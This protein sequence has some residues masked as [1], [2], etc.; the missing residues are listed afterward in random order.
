M[1]LVQE[2]V[3]V[4]LPNKKYQILIG[5]G[6]HQSL[7]D[8]MHSLQGE[9]VILITDDKVAGFWLKP[10]ASQMS[11]IVSRLDE[12]VVREGEPSKSVETCNQLWQK[13]LEMGTDR[14]TIVVAL[15]GGVVGDLA[16]FLAASFARGIRFVQIPTSLLA[17]VDSSVGGKV[18]INLPQSK[19]MVGAFWQ[20]ESVIIDPLVLQ[21]L[22]EPNFRAGMAEVIKYGLIMDDEF[23]HFLKSSVDPIRGRDP[24][25][26]AKVIAWC[27]RCKAQVVEEDEK[28]TSGRRVILNY[29][30]T[31][32]HA[33]ENVFGYGTFLHGEA[34]AIGM[35]CAARLA[36]ELGMVDSDF[37]KS[38]T[39]L[40]LEFG[41]PVECPENRHDELLDAMKRDKKVAA[42]KLSLI[43]PTRIG[44]VVS[45]AAPSDEK[46]RNSLV[47]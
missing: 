29:G 4:T 45:M 8:H 19:N 24:Q 18:G 7:P 13:M 3:D 34:I 17:Q 37:L 38:Q 31:Y 11:N 2:I 30:H 28:E 23:F 6:L 25:I 43:L 21:T 46:I 15:G 42:G 5:P 1:S 26:L 16:G 9:H 27:C 39:E 44:N 47:N 32:G 12:I 33:I 10:F 22:D 35:T 40:F 36:M 14:R 41:L 20:P